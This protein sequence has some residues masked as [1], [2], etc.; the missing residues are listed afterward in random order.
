MLNRIQNVLYH[1]AHHI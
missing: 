1:L